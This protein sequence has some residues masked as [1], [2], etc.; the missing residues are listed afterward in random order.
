LSL[1]VCEQMSQNVQTD[2]SRLKLC[3]TQ[4]TRRWAGSL[5][6]FDGQCLDSH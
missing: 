3:T 4:L 5:V 2:Y 6:E 1:P